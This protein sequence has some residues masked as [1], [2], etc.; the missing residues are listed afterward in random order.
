KQVHVTH[1]ASSRMPADARDA[2]ARAQAAGVSISGTP[3]PG[4]RP[5]DIAI[6]A[7]LGIGASRAPDAALAN[8]IALLASLPCPVLAVDVP[9]GLDVWTGQPLGDSCVQ[10]QH[11]LSLLTLK[12]GLFTAAG[13]DH[14][15]SVWFDDLQCDRGSEP[16]DAWLTGADSVA[17]PRR[18]HAQHK[19]SFGDVAI[20]GGAAGMTG[21]ALLAARAAHAA[22]AGRVYVSL[23][24]DSDLSVDPQRP[25][26]MFRRDWWKGRDAALAQSTVVCGCGG[27][28]AIREPLPRLLSTAARLVLDAD[29]LNAISTDTQLQSL[30]RARAARQRPT[31]LTPHPLEAARLLGSTAA[32]VQADRL[33]A[34]QTLA[35]QFACVVLLKGSGSVIAAPGAAPHINPTGSAALATAGTGD[36]LAGWLGGLWSQ[37]S[38]A[39]DDGALQVA[40]SAAYQHGAAADSAQVAVM[41]AGDLIDR[42]HRV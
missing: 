41:R 12:P 27:G 2:L 40:C 31:V 35:E 24:D 32:Q 28:E 15:G 42:L 13:R 17:M 1:H 16:P 30:L 14:A 29:A 23:L 19:G 25:E 38:A 37:Q 8:S 7:L 11:T 9:S 3:L 5:H 26:L 22:G 20:V 34:A 4:L 39:T 33:K 10:A 36:V 21:A 6:D 18:L